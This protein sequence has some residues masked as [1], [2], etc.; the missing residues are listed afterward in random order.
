M[1]NTKAWWNSHRTG[2]HDS[3]PCALLSRETIVSFDACLSWKTSCYV[4]FWESYL[5][6]RTH[7]FIKWT[8]KHS[9][10]HRALYCESQGRGRRELEPFS[11]AIQKYYSRFRNFTKKWARWFLH[12]CQATMSTRTNQNNSRAIRGRHFR[13]WAFLCWPSFSLS[14]VCIILSSTIMLLA[15]IMSTLIFKTFCK[16][17]S[18]ALTLNHVWSKHIPPPE[19]SRC[20]PNE[21]F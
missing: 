13:A 1:C 19:I 11:S 16:T 20:S 8:H 14:S 15:E 17:H 2:S 12:K 5:I 10:T 7:N 21:V 4:L 18:F 6:I 3:R 9:H